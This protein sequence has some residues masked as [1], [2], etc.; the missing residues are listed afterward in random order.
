MNTLVI[1]YVPVIHEGY[2]RFMRE[3]P[4]DARI[5]LCGQDIMGRF[6][7]IKKDIRAV[8]PGIAARM[9]SAVLAREVSVLTEEVVEEAWASRAKIVAPDEEEVR[10]L[11]DSLFPQSERE[12]R[13]VFLRWDRKKVLSA[14]DID[15]PVAEDLSVHGAWM[16]RAR[17]AAG[18]SCDWWLQVGAVLVPVSGDPLVAKNEHVP[19]GRMPYVLGDPR[20]FFSAGIHDDLTTAEH[21]EARLIGEAAQHGI[22]LSGA[23]L[24]VTVFPCPRCARLIA[25]AGIS[26][27]YF[28]GG[29]STLRGAED[30]RARGVELYRLPQTLP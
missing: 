5:A 12:F 15:A 22:S 17:L 16:E 10:H 3:I 13:S 24:Y 8:A 27:L 30:L 25:R 28:Q 29:F 20:S 9:L 19:D 14:E 11:A 2:L 23:S 18:G 4:D 26:R 6:P 1:A 21:A 7:W